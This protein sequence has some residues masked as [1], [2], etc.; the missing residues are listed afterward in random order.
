MSAHKEIVAVVGP[1][2]SGAEVVTIW[3][4]SVDDGASVKHKSSIREL[5]HKSS[6]GSVVVTS[7]A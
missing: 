1:N 6:D 4:N 3:D 2:G 7:Y 5:V